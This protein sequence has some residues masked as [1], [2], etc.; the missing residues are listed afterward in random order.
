MQY[1]QFFL[2]FLF[3]GDWILWSKQMKGGFL[4]AE[5]TPGQ[6]YLLFVKSESASSA[7]EVFSWRAWETVPYEL[8]LWN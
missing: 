7:I 5:A 2:L 8:W 6:G 4:T 1:T 3:L